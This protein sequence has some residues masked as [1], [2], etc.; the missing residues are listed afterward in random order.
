L[1]DVSR[2]TRGKIHLQLQPLEVAVAVASAVETSRP[3]IESRKHELTLSL[4]PEAVQ[5]RADLARLAQILSNLL[6]NAAKYTEEGGHIWFTVEREG[7][8]AVFRVRDTGAGIPPEVLPRVF[9]LFTQADQSL[10]RSQ[11]G[12][13]I[14]LTLVHRLVEMHQGSVQAFSAGAG[15]GSEFVVRLP[16]LVGEPPPP[17]ANGAAPA[18]GTPDMYRVLVVDDNVDA[19]DSLALLVRLDGHEV[20][21]AHDGQAALE[22]AQAFHPQVIL[23]DIGLPRMDGY[24][25]ARRLREQ[26]GGD[27]YIMAAVTGYGQDEDRL[28]AHDAGFDHHLLKPVDPKVLRQVITAMSVRE[29]EQKM[30]TPVA[31]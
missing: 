20:R 11:G 8:E 14:G 5:V 24:E 16:L 12:L 25:V 13:G 2:I 18:S 6:N 28:R 19:A 27:R 30:A 3:L 4:P 21:T 23:L 9:D 31:K 1:L 22:A 10:D 15:Q 26:P 29:E 7:G 17:A